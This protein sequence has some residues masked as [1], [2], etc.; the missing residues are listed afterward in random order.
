MSNVAIGLAIGA[1]VHSSTGGTVGTGSPDQ[2]DAIAILVGL[3]LAA[4]ATAWFYPRI[5]RASL[6]RVDLCFFAAGFYLMVILSE[7]AIAWVV[8]LVVIALGLN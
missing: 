6:D 4:I 5:R 2:A 1:A 3:V 7:V 8:S